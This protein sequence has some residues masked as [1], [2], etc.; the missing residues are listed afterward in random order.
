MKVIILPVANPPI[1]DN[2]IF[3]YMNPL[4]MIASFT[5]MKLT[6]DFQLM[7]INREKAI[8]KNGLVIK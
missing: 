7:W 3:K 6:L 4:S 8:A 5:V 2:N 1:N